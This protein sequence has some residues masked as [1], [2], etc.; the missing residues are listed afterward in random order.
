MQSCIQIAISSIVQSVCMTRRSSLKTGQV[1]FGAGTGTANTQ[2]RH[3]RRQGGKPHQPL[4]D[5]I[6]SSLEL[7]WLSRHWADSCRTFFFFFFCVNQ[8]AQLLLYHLRN[9]VVTDVT[10]KQAQTMR[11]V[12]KA[13]FMCRYFERLGVTTLGLT[14]WDRVLCS[15]GIS[16]CSW[17]VFYHVI[18]GL[19]DMEEN[20]QTNLMLNI[21]Q[22][23]TPSTQE[24]STFLH[25]IMSLNFLSCHTGRQ[26]LVQRGKGEEAALG[27]LVL[28]GE[29]K[30]TT[31]CPLSLL[32][33]FISSFP[34]LIFF[35]FP[36][37][38]AHLISLIF[39]CNYLG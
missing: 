33:L 26:P 6:K 8:Y 2:L 24:I 5:C 19:D 17:A 4:M 13:S 18:A 38:H 22:K 35:L 34:F 36:I 31:A 37:L 15:L 1:S 23:F 25:P 27:P 28:V 10:R 7:S 14:H 30:I 39:K 29:K 12:S 3:Q 32:F 9:L 20:P 21:I 16:L 11:A